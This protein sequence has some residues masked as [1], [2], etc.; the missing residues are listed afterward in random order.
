MLFTVKTLSTSTLS[1]KKWVPPPEIS[2]W[3]AFDIISALLRFGW[4]D[5]DV[6]FETDKIPEKVVVFPVNDWFVDCEIKVFT[7]SCIFFP[8][9]YKVEVEFS[10]PIKIDGATNDIWSPYPLYPKLELLEPVISNEL[11]VLTK[12]FNHKELIVIFGPEALRFVFNINL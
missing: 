4:I 12:P 9:I 7:W 11:F 5:N 1:Q 3:T 6:E 2:Y 8:F 10:F